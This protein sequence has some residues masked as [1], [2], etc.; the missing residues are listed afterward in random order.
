MV[1]E[2]DHNQ[3]ARELM[4][5]RNAWYRLRP[6]NPQ[7]PFE[8]REILV[9]NRIHFGGI[10]SQDDVFEGDPIISWS[11]AQPTYADI[12]ELARR[13]MPSSSFLAQRREAGRIFNELQD[14]NHLRAMQQ[15][16]EEKHKAMYHGSS[17]LSFFRDA[18]V[19]KSW[20]MYAGHGAGYGLLFDFT[21]PWLFEAFSGM[22]ESPMVPFE[23][24]YLEIGERPSIELSVAPSHPDAAFDELKRALLTK[25]G[26]W[27]AQG[28]ERLV[29][30]GIPPSHVTFPA[31]SLRALILGPRISQKNKAE[32]IGL[33]NSRPPLPI[34]ESHVAAAGHLE[35]TVLDAH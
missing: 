1:T 34:I 24:H 28:E 5:E 19:M 31:E 14:P 23:V 13:R 32:L 25:T 15:G 27:A 8:P 6:F 16:I 10:R 20:D 26:E 29:R 35:F 9:A 18:T 33:A 2:T 21:V 3:F 17:I 11:A 7:F 22:G 12:R 4:V 30:V